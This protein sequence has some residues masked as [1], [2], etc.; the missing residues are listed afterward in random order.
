MIIAFMLIRTNIFKM[1]KINRE[2]PLIALSKCCLL[3]RLRL[4]QLMKIFVEKTRKNNYK[5]TS[6]TKRTEYRRTWM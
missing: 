5:L 3:R 2:S 6:F 1:Q 4:V